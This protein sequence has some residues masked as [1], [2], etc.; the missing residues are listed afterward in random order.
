MAHYDYAHQGLGA[1]TSSVPFVSTPTAERDGFASLFEAYKSAFPPGTSLVD[2]TKAIVA[3]N[4]IP[5]RTSSI[6]PWIFGMS[7]KRFPYNAKDNPG[8][9]GGP[10][11]VGWAHFA[12]GNKIMLPDIPRP[13]VN[14]P[15]AAI[16]SP[17]AI[18]PPPSPSAPVTVTEQ[19]PWWKSPWVLGGGAVALVA[20][21]A[22]VGSG[23][24]TSSKT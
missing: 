2:F 24:D 8:M 6:E 17:A 20:L 3:A 7:G 19:A 21:V 13:G 22:L 23:D 12:A 5:Y 11:N 10:K 18:P 16:P 9:Y 4:G 14:P 1:V 15:P